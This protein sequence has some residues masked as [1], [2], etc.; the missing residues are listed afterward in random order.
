MPLPTLPPVPEFPL[1]GFPEKVADYWRAA[2]AALAVP[3]EYVAVPGLALLGAAVGRSRAAGVKPGYEEVPLFWVAVIAP[4]GSTKS[5]SL[6]SARAPLAKAER[7]WM[8]T[9]RKEVTRFDAEADRHAGRVKDWK[10]GGCEGEPPTPP[11]RSAAA[12]QSSPTV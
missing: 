6:G 10:A 11:R 5:A 8:E 2:A 9:H 12:G 7:A 3:V 4:P 1:H